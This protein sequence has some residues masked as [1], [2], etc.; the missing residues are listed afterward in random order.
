MT[1]R[2]IEIY[3]PVQATSVCL[4]NPLSDGLELIAVIQPRWFDGPAD[5]MPDE[6]RLPRKERPHVKVIL[7]KLVQRIREEFEEAAG[8][9]V[10]VGEAAR[11]FG[12]DVE[13]SEQVLTKLYQLGF[14]AKDDEGRYR[15]L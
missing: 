13:T 10:S 1:A 11:F 2:L 3:G 5:R 15:Q 6:H 12:L 14:L 9:R 4:H 7:I 8:L